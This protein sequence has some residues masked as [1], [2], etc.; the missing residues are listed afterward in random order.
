M[1]W[2]VLVVKFQGALVQ[3]FLPMFI[4]GHTTPPETVFVAFIQLLTQVAEDMGGSGRRS[5]RFWPEETV[6][7]A[8][9]F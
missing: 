5:A 6:L 7:M 9:Y 3:M 2:R 4:P 8:V 1:C